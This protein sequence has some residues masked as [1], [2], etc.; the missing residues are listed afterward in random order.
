MILVTMPTSKV[1]ST[2]TSLL[3]KQ[4]ISVRVGAYSVEKAHKLFPLAEIVPL[5][6]NNAATVNAALTGVKGLYLAPPR[7]DFPVQPLLR[8]IKLAQ[9]LGVKRVTLLSAMGIEDTNTNICHLEQGVEASGIDFTSLRI[10]VLLQNY[11]THFTEVI[12]KQGFFVEPVDD[13]QTSFVDARD[14]AAVAAATLTQERHARQ[15]YTLTGSKAYTRASVAAAISAVTGKNIRY[16]PLSDKEWRAQVKTIGW[17]DE[18]VDMMLGYYHTH[19]R[20]GRSAA[21]TDTVEQI[22]QRP[23]ITL[24]QFVHDYRDIWL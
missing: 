15:I 9:E 1:G 14:V 23:P 10:N 13:E 7:E 19:I 4:N 16:L 20:S 18:F 11:S 5:D 6:L 22:L 24:F 21:I 3:L 12:Q 8:V 17:T 2:L